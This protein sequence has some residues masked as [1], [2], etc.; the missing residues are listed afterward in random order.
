MSQLAKI[1][2]VAVKSV[3]DFYNEIHNTEKPVGK[4]K[5]VIEHVFIIPVS[6]K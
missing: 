2:T 5:E 6:A 3:M 1:F 4:V